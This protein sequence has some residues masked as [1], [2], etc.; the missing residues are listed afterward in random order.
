MSNL[1]SDPVSLATTDERGGE[2]GSLEVLK[3]R[4]VPLGG[5]RAMTVWRSLPQRGRTTIGAWCFIDHYGPDPVDNELNPGM[6]VPPHPHTGLQTVSWLFEG[7]IEHRD[8]VGSHVLV[9]PGDMNL[10]TAGRGIS[11][12][13]VATDRTTIL[14]GVQLWTVLPDDSRH[15]EPFFE[16][17]PSVLTQVGDVQV[18]VFLGEFAGVRAKAST[19]SDLF[20]AE[21][22]IPP[23]HRWVVA[24]DPKHE[25]GLLLDSGSVTLSHRGES[26]DLVARDLGFAPAG[27]AELIVETGDEE[28]RA[29]FLGGEPFTEPI[30]MWWNFIGRTHDEIE[31]LRNEW[32]YDVIAESNSAGRF[33][34][35]EGGQEALPAPAMPTVRLKSRSNR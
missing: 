31:A 15:V 12:S 14:H 8:S 32:Q 35:V 30:V 1:E 22:I 2:R 16:Q 3:A 19:F 18:R 7:E 34:T 27:A 9:R 26:V 6:N 29:L 20:G 25:H 28:V 33:G 17:V 10:M 21:V 13:E 24:I 11:H 4:P 23:R 5:V